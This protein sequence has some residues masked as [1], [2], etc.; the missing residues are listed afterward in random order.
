MM[1]P[2]LQL[3]PNFTLD[4]AVTTQ[5]RGVDNYPPKQILAVM[6]H[7]A[8][9]MEEVRKILGKPI[10]VNSWYRNQAVNLAVGG[11]KKSAHMEGRAVDFI[12]PL[13]G[14]PWEVCKR[15]E[16]ARMDLKFDQLI[17]ENTWIH[18]SFVIPPAVPRLEVLTYNPVTKSYLNGIVLG[19]GVK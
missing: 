16:A 9:R 15:L 10:Y 14:T 2:P 5:V 4:E 13:Y 12:C 6:A 7:T 8:L 3:S 11:S 19:K 17:Y 18:I 1:T